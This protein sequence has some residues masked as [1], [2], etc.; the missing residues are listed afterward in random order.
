MPELV[1]LY[2]FEPDTHEQISSRQ[3]VHDGAIARDAGTHAEKVRMVLGQDALGFRGN[4]H[5]NLKSFDKSSHSSGVINL[6]VET[7]NEDWTPDCPEPRHHPRHRL[8]RGRKNRRR[9]K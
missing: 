5:R 1:R 9:L 2:W 3:K 8:G 4:E 6:E 7:Q